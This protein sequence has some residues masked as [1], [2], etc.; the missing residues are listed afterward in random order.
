MKRSQ[1]LFTRTMFALGVAAAV[2]AAANQGASNQGTPTYVTAQVVSLDVQNRMLVIRTGEGRQQRVELD[3]HV[4][5]L[6]GIK[7][8][9]RV[10]VTMR[11][12]PA[13]ARVSAI[14]KSPLPAPAKLPAA[15]RINTSG[16]V[17][18]APAQSPPSPSAEAAQSAVFAERV[19][20]LAQ[21]ATRIDSLWT[22]FRTTCN[23]NVTARYDGAREWLALWDNSLSVDLSNGF[24][25][26]LYNQII[27]AGVTVSEGMASAE[28]T[29]RA[30]LLPGTMREIR[31]RYSMDWER[32]GHKPPERAKP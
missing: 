8:G 21:E 28:E 25:R 31:R 32:W 18:P 11:G 20:A 9:D 6:Q 27:G 19:A 29:A 3:D 4:A 14:A 12:E 23:V 2:P 5:G 24:C 26:D 30:G 22:A 15:G 1:G 10:I 13:M 16:R 7:P 17:T